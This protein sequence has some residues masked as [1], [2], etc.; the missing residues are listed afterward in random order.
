MLKDAVSISG[1]SITYVI[2]KAL[3]IGGDIYAP[4]QPCSHKCQNDCVKIRCK[5][6]KQI[7]IDCTLCPKNKPYELLKT[8][9]IGGPSIVFCRYA[10]AEMT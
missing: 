5:V 4:G 9:I 7:K 6:C 1:I 10:E 2:N 8:G 3:D